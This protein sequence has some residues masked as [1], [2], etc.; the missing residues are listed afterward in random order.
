M[1]TLESYRP[2]QDLPAIAGICTIPEAAQEGFSVENCV[3]RLKRQHWAFKRL[4]DVFIRRL[5]AEPI[6]EL[7]MGFSLHAYY[8]SEHAAAWRKRVGEMREPPLGLEEPP[9]KALD[10]FFD[11]ISSAPDTA[12]LLTG[13]YK[14]AM[15][16]LID[17]LRR[18]GDETNRLVDHP[19]FRICRFALIEAEEMLEYGSRCFAALVTQ[20]R[21]SEL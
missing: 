7:K 11:E 19:S 20:E 18:H 17:A 14:H 2:Y 1:I 21:S 9:D 10:V 5:T 12:A 8:C 16:A 6:Y 4:H 3:K 15:P 13:L